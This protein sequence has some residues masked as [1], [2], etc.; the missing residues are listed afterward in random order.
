MKTQAIT[1]LQMKTYASIP[2]RATYLSIVTKLHYLLV[3]LGLV[4]E[5]DP[6]TR[7]IIFASTYT[8]T[9][10]QNSQGVFLDGTF[11]MSPK[12]WKQVIFVTTEKSE[13]NMST[14]FLFF[15]SSS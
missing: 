15:R 9:L 11:R 7:V 12:L 13:K 2:V 3:I 1:F 4:D 10:M 5:S 8:L 6:N 14:L